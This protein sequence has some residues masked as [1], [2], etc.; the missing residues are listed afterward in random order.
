MKVTNLRSKDGD[1]IDCVYIYQQPAFDNPLL[2]DHWILQMRPNYQPELGFIENKFSNIKST[3]NE[4]E[5][6][7]ISQLLQL[8]NT[9][10]KSYLGFSKINLCEC[11]SE[12]SICII[13]IEDLTV[14]NKPTPLSMRNMLNLWVTGGSCDSDLNVIEAGWHVNFFPE[15][16]GDKRTNFF[17][18]WIKNNF[19]SIG[20]YNLLC[21]GF[22]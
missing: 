5:Q 13:R 6:K 14:G 4:L 16:Y 3:N 22:A 1:I 17:I 11:H 19:R 12:S 2:K 20:C 21:P 7:P 8:A 9:K 15:L 10:K 18:Y